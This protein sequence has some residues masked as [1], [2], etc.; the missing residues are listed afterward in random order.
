MRIRRLFLLGRQTR[1]TRS[2]QLRTRYESF[3]SAAQI[4]ARMGSARGRNAST[5]YDCAQRPPATNARPALPFADGSSE[6]SGCG[7]LGGGTR[8]PWRREPAN[9]LRSPLPETVHSSRSYYHHHRDSV[10]LFPIIFASERASR[11]GITGTPPILN[12]CAPLN[13]VANA[14]EPPTPSPAR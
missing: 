9:D 6:H 12:P 2:S 1:K 3:I 7:V 10:E 4:K 11:K 14:R 13:T 5:T 8:R